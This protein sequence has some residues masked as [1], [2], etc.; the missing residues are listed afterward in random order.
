MSDLKIP[1]SN[2]VTAEWLTS[3]LRSGGVIKDASVTS[4]EFEGDIAA[5]VGFMGQLA[6]IKP[7]YDQA[8]EGAPALIIA[9]F[10]AAAPDNR[11][12]AEVFRFYE[13]ET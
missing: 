10:P 6:R 1:A 7:T 4:L 5:G 12:I 13:I 9:K 8:E 11:E 2:E 3:A